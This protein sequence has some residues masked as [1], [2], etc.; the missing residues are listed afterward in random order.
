[1]SNGVFRIFN[2]KGPKEDPIEK[3]KDQV[4]RAQ[5]TYR[6]RK[7]KYTRS[8][9]AAFS[10]A[11]VHE[12]QLVNQCVRLQ[13]TVH[14]LAEL[15][16]KNGIQTPPELCYDERGNDSEQMWL[17]NTSSAS[18]S[19]TP[20]STPMSRTEIFEVMTHKSPLELSMSQSYTGKTA[21]NSSMK[22]NDQASVNEV[23]NTTGALKYRSLHLCH[24]DQV[25]VGMEFVLTIEEPCR[26]HIHGDLNKP[27]EPSGHAIT[28][29]AQ[30]HRTRNWSVA[31]GTSG[32]APPDQTCSAVI[33][34]RMRALSPLLCSAGET[35]PIQAWD[36]IRCQP[37]FGG[38][39]LHDLRYLAKKLRDAVNCH[40][41]GAVVELSVV[42]DLLS[43]ILVRGNSF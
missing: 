7:D 37:Q 36:L 9:E 14:V 26:D 30:L 1:M 33:L 10:R 4:R 11:Q 25:A 43:E 15:L 6:A 28:A 3:R 22:R 18:A 8:L 32:P 27:D 13:A 29:T 20:T 34:D 5:K 41:Y 16:V 40:G 38:L 2:P 17:T 21:Q 12:E 39:A 42:E 19:S 24:L 31:S 23:N 35:T